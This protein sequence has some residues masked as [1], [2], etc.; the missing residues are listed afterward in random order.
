MVVL[1]NKSLN[2]LSKL[3]AGRFS[4]F[5]IKEGEY[6][7]RKPPKRMQTSYIKFYASLSAGKSENAIE[8]ARNA[9]KKWKDMSENEKVKYRPSKE[10]EQKHEREMEEY[11]RTYSDPFKKVAYQN[12]IMKEVWTKQKPK[13]IQ[14]GVKATKEFTAKLTQADKDKYIEKANK[15]R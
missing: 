2:M 1:I 5:M 10:E 15:I 7:I 13:S 4:S 6:L 12:I 8:M 9:A 3:I 14:E 11:R